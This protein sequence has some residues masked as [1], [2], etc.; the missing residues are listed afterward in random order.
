MTA[1]PQTQPGRMIH[2]RL[3]ARRDDLERCCC[4]TPEAL[5]LGIQELVALGLARVDGDRILPARK[6]KPR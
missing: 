3:P 6:G 5:A 4:L 1:R 2:G